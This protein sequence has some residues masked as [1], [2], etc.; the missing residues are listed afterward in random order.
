V[1]KTEE[2]VVVSLN[3]LA[4]GFLTGTLLLFSNPMGKNPGKKK[5]KKS[6]PGWCSASN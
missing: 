1:Y 3:T 4:V 5:K 2:T 6:C